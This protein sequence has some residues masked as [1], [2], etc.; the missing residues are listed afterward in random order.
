MEDNFFTKLLQI[1]LRLFVN[2]SF[3]EPFVILG[4]WFEVYR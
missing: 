1:S 4:R 2:V 3:K